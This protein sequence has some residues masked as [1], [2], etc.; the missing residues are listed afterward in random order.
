MKKTMTRIAACSLAVLIAFNT[1]AIPKSKAVAFGS[2]FASAVTAAF[3]TATGF[4]MDASGNWNGTSADMYIAN[5]LDGFLRDFAEAREMTKAQ[6][7]ELIYDGVEIVHGG[8]VKISTG[9]AALLSG[10]TDW[11]IDKFGLIGEDGIP[12]TEPVGIVANTIPFPALPD[13]DLTVYP[14]VV[15]W[16]NAEAGTFRYYRAGIDAKVVPTYSSVQL[17]TSGTGSC[18]YYNAEKAAWFAFSEDVG[19]LDI[20]LSY[21]VASSFSIYDKAGTLLV[22]ESDV[23]AFAG[24]E[25]WTN[26]ALTVLLPSDYEPAPTFEEQYSMVIDTGMSFEDEQT[27]IDSILAGVASGTLNPTYD[28]ELENRDTVVPGEVTD[29]QAGIL[30]WVKRIAQSVISLP[31]A[32]ADKFAAFPQAIAKAVEGIFVPDAALTTEI[33]DTFSEKFAFVP[34]LHALGVD[35]LNLKPDSEPPVIWIH[36]EDTEGSINYGG[37]VKALDMSWYERYKED[38]DRIIGGFLWLGFLW[39]LFKRAAAIIKGGEMVSEYGY[40]I[41]NG[42]RGSGRGGRHL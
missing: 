9:V 4:S 6:F 14:Y 34:Q 19:T 28:I 5:S 3:M 1:F 35:L 41:D 7:E 11:L 10:F 25:D 2:Q 8:F 24:V 15:L 23:Y 42:Y 27:F 22:P 33:T 31:Q 20:T 17:Q 39:M 26:S 30:S 13:I 40:D 37:T 18:W 16:H 36:L 32:I 29:T 38:G 21:I 12:V